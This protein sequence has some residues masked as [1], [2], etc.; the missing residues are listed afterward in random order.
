MVRQESLSLHTTLPPAAGLAGAHCGEGR[1]GDPTLNWVCAS[2]PGGFLFC[3]AH[4]PL[5]R[6]DFELMGGWGTVG[7]GC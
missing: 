1:L 6:S 3:T 5:V 2:S 4:P 7:R